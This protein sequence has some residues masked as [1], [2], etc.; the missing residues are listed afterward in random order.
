MSDLLFN[1]DGV[2]LLGFGT[3][4]GAGFEFITKGTPAQKR[5]GVAKETEYLQDKLSFDGQSLVNWGSDNNFPHKANEMIRSVGVL[6]TGLKFMRNFTLGQGIFPVE[7]T[8][9]DEQGNEQ[10]QVINNPELTAFCESRLVRRYMEKAMRDYFKFGVANVQLITNADASK[11]VGINTINTMFC[12]YT[13]AKNGIIEKVVVSGRWPDSPPKEAYEVFDLL[14]EYDPAADL[15]RRRFE[16]SLKNKS[17]VFSIKDSWSNN[18]YYSE[19][20]WWAAYLAGWVDVA[21]VVPKFLL[22]AYANQVTWKWHV[23]IP[24]AFWDKKFPKEDYATPELRKDAIQEYM[25]LIE[26]NICSQENADKPIFTFYEINPN[27]GKAEEQWIIEP[28]DNKSKEG[29]RLVTSAAANSE[30]M[31]AMMLNPNVLGAGMPGGVYSGNQ[32]GSNI[33]EAFLVNIA[34]AWL[35]R[36]NLLDPL[37]AYLQYNGVSGI[38][39]RFRNT[40]L[41]TLDTGAGTTKKLS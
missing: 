2:P 34:N 25:D 19:P 29:D 16:G 6:N 41:T 8:G 4:A 17:V 12:R 21:R 13:E 14:D 20:I 26:T 1:N 40:I 32:G 24:Y 39:L 37:E 28:L 31:F 35:D 23:K 18:D 22:K 27:N 30:I 5:P 36:Q 3:G 11:M 38:Q 7:V 9:Y 15:Q 10:L 33:R